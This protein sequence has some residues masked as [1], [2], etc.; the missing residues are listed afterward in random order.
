MS[1]CDINDTTALLV[2]DLQP[3]FTS[4]IQD[5]KYSLRVQRILHHMRSILPPSHIVHI[6][7]NY[8]G[9]VMC[10]RS[11]VLRPDLPIP[12]DITGTEWA[13]ELDNEPVIQKTTINGFHNTSLEQ[14]LHSI[15]VRKVF[16]IG[17]LTAACIHSTAVGAMNRGFHASLIDEGCIDKTPQRHTQVI[18][19]FQDYLYEVICMNDIGLQ[20][21]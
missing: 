15:R 1:H 10:P 12:T 11:R 6:R 5:T 16:L 19:L 7:A 20:T 2:V 4:N 9:S 13:K 8:E 18:E 17:M 21:E 14:Y 3:V